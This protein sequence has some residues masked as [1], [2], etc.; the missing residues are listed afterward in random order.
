MYVCMNV[1][2]YVCVC[3]NVCMYV[4]VWMYVCMCMNVCICGSAGRVAGSKKSIAWSWMFRCVGVATGNNKKYLFTSI[5]KLNPNPSGLHKKSQV[6][7]YEASFF[8]IN[9]YIYIP[10]NIPELDLYLFQS[11]SPQFH[12]RALNF[13]CMKMSIF[14]LQNKRVYTTK[15]QLKQK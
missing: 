15:W 6:L 5:C 8:Y 14:F 11:L 7:L 12:Y 4:C 1:C 2:M 13:L 9:I 3:M 10:I